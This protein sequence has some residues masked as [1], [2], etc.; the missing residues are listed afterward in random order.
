M[1]IMQKLFIQ[2]LSNVLMR[3]A[4]MNIVKCILW[5]PEL[6][7]FLHFL[8]LQLMF[9]NVNVSHFQFHSFNRASYEVSY[10]WNYPFGL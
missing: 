8:Y 2:N 7:L 4:N 5:Y 9:H 3:K 6:H 1:L 10:P